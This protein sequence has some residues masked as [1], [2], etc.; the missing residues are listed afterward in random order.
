MASSGECCEIQSI[1][2]AQHCTRDNHTIGTAYF[3]DWLVDKLIRG[4]KAGQVKISA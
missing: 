1:G 3:G 4:V 2:G